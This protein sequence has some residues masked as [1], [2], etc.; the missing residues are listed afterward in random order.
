VGSPIQ[1]SKPV[2]AAGSEDDNAPVGSAGGRSA[3]Q[4]TVTLRE[5][6]SANRAKVETLRVAAEQRGYVDG[7][8]RSLTEA[9]ATPASRP[10][11]RA[12]YAGEVP[13]GFVMLADDVPPNDPSIRWRYYL[14]R[15]LVDERYQR[16]GYGRSAL[17]R[18]VEHLRTRPGADA[19]MTS[20]VPGEHSPLDFYL[21]YGFESTGEW[22][23][24]EQVLRLP[25]SGPIGR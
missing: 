22:F 8:S 15:M 19:L 24:H 25:L 5:I 3:H 9:A 16:R 4:V 18:V 20:I 23:D 17:D 21:R 6:T 2:P 10:W 14:W 7:V 1:N 12:I 13:V 11:Y